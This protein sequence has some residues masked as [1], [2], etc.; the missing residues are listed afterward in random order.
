MATIIK[1]T[2]AAR[3]SPAIAFHLDDISEQVA[4]C[5]DEARAQAQTILNESR[6]EAQ[7]IRQQAEEDG[8]TEATRRA[9]ASVD[10]KIGQRIE[11]LLPALSAA[12]AQL[13]DA[14]QA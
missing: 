6:L 3:S 10:D 2:S 11:T 8:L 5:L 4:R 13:A 14:R 1:S 7:R 12:I 9:E